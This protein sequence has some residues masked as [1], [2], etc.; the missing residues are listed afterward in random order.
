MSATTHEPPVV[1]LRGRGAR[2]AWRAVRSLTTPLVPDDYVD[3]I[4]PLRSSRYLRAR[5][6]DVHDETPDTC[7]VTLR[8]G[9]GWRGHRPGQFIRVGVDID[10]VRLWRAYSITSGPRPDDCLTITVKAQ[11]GGLV[12]SHLHARL[13]A[14]QV[15]QLEQAAGDFVWDGGAEPVLFVTGGSGITPVMGM[16]RHRLAASDGDAAAPDG[17]VPSGGAA[18]GDDVV[19]VHSAGHPEDVIFADDL[20]TLDAS[21]RIRLIE[22]HTKVDGRL[23]PAQLDDLV[24][25]WRERTLYACGPAGMLRTLRELAELNGVAGRLHTESSVVELAEPGEGGVVTLHLPGGER[26]VEVPGDGS[27]LDAA[28]AADVLVPS[29]CRM[30]ICYGCVLPLRSGSVRDL[31]TGEVTTAGVGDG[32]MV[33]TCISSAAGACSI[34]RD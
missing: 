22:R 5:V 19:V 3:L 24:P 20:H 10:G 12:S 29:G 34:G 31:R 25:D 11:T 28:E 32:V 21:G 23:E 18:D 30:G 26:E 1:S 17:S 33:Q 15:V 2:L 16:L 6:I 27:I 9:V 7:T 13:R 8:P 4:D 14:G